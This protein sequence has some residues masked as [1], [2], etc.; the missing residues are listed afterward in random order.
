[1]GTRIKGLW[2]VLFGRTTIF[3]FLIL[4][5]LAVIIGG[6]GILGMK[7][8]LVA[9]YI[10]GVL[11][12]IVLIYLINNRLNSSFKLMW[13]ILI[14][15]TPLIGVPFF[16]YTRIQPGTRKIARR[17]EEQISEQRP[18]LLPEKDTVDR[19]AIDAGS[20]Y[21]LFKYMFEEA[22]YPVYDGCGL[23]YYPFGEDNFEAL[24]REL[25]KAEKFI[26][27]EYF[28][29][30]KG[31]MWDAVLNILRQ[32]VKEGVEVRVLYD[33]TNTMMNL[34]KKY[35][36]VM[37]SWGIQCRVFSPMKPVI[38]THQNF[39]DHRKIVVIDGHTAFTGGVNLADE[40]INKK[41]RFGVW[42]DT[43]VMVKG[44]AANSFTL[45][46]LQMW[47]IKS[48]WPDDYGKYMYKGVEND[49][50]IS[51]GGYVVPYG[52]SPLDDED[53]GKKIY[54]DILNR[55]SQYVHIMTPYLILDEEMT[56][57]LIFAAQRGI[58][59]K[60]ILPHIPD[61]KYAYALARTHYEELIRGG[62][63]LYEYRPGFVHAKNFVSDDEKAVVGTINLDFRS[64][65]LH[66][67]CATYIWHNPIVE[68]V[69]T[70][71]QETLKECQ[72]MTLKHCKE[73]PLIMKVFGR[74]LRLIA[75]LM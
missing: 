49:E 41:E 45:M 74:A 53:V 37:E 40:Y 27:L 42:K 30:D 20:E 55:A 3:V 70:D 57:T 67:E 58:D 60:I 12:I 72:R 16:I 39:R 15:A 48:T 22:H 52:D 59:V 13:I 66:F 5:Q 32:K 4:I 7:E 2:K 33:G 38:T 73:T 23:E 21:G 65:F 63:K 29:I 11:A 44:K 54:L 14:V 34:P 47:N 51:Y 17:V 69:E 71:F 61:K 43:A 68:E 18:W 56:N 19:L 64:L 10:V 28:I 6:I 25:K 31:E 26:F 1:M 36:R 9:N 62:V 46:F 24:L 35:P 50:N 75:P 8:V